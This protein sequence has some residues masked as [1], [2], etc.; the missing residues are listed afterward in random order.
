[1]TII[2]APQQTLKNKAIVSPLE[3]QFCATESL[4][5]T[6]FLMSNHLFSN[7]FQGWQWLLKGVHVKQRKKQDEE[8]KRKQE[9]N[10]R[11]CNQECLR[12]CRDDIFHFLSFPDAPFSKLLMDAIKLSEINFYNIL[13]LSS[14][15]WLSTKGWR[16]TK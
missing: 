10:K 6:Y 16:R 12:N 4:P 2:I 11:W 14:S 5:K 8:E 9:N 1:M 7:D 13:F 3:C 15:N